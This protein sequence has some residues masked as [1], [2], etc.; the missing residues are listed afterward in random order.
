MTKT[1]EMAREKFHKFCEMHA[2]NPDLEELDW[3]DMS[4]GFFMAC[5]LTSE[6]AC[7]L[8]NIVRYDDQYFIDRA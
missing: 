8:A 3:Y 6:E 2:E 4:V 5:N 1:Q 7:E